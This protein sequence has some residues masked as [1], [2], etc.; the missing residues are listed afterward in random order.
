MKLNSYSLLKYAFIIGAV[1]DAVIALMWFFIASGV[2]IPN[3]LSGHN[4]IGP[5]YQFAMFISGMF[6]A[7]WSIILSWGA[8]NPLERRG[9]LVITS[10]FLILSVA[11]E[12]LFFM[13]LLGGTWFIFGV[14]KRLLISMFFILVY[15]Y[16]FKSEAAYSVDTYNNIKSTKPK[17]TRFF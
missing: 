15:F 7:G 13:H 1:I 6:M 11:A 4:G 9:L 3:I 2:N 17:Q 8:I 10:G 14:T 12:Y 16:S 5:D